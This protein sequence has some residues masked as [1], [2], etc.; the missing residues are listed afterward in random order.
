MLRD[1][2]ALARILPELNNLFGVPHMDN[3]YPGTD[4]GLHSLS[5]LQQAAKV[6]KKPVVRCSALMH[7]INPDLIQ[8]LSSRLK[9][10]NE[11]KDLALLV[12]LYHPSC[13][14]SVN[15]SAEEINSIL[16]KIDAF[17]RPERFSEF[18]HA[19]EAVCF[20]IKEPEIF[21]NPRTELLK[22]AFEIAL[23]IN[24]QEIIDQG[25]INEKIGEELTK[26][27]ISE[28]ETQLNISP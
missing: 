9:L 12:S 6:S 8:N 15:Y 24:T 23:T 14:Q 3:T 18:L 27:R 4:T 25:F 2:D 28:I 19:C 22:K 10:P 21:S 20:D 13:Q 1:C 11:Y 17:R 7:G 26:R 5:V 16:N